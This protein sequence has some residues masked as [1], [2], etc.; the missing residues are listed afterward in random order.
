MMDSQKTLIDIA[1]VSKRV[2]RTLVQY[3]GRKTVESFRLEKIVVGSGAV[4]ET[5]NKTLLLNDGNIDDR[6]ADWL[7]SNEPRAC[8]R[9]LNQMERILNGKPTHGGR[10]FLNPSSFTHTQDISNEALRLFQIHQG[11]FHFLLMPTDVW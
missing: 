5:L 2:V 3:A 10:N 11:F 9:T 6:L 8:L 4:L 1:S 7:G